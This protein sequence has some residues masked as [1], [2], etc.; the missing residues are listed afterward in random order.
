MNT[1]LKF[2]PEIDK[3]QQKN[4]NGTIYHLDITS[5]HLVE[6]FFFNVFETLDPKTISEK[7]EWLSKS[8]E[9]RIA[10]SAF[11]YG[12][13]YIVKQFKTTEW[14]LLID[15]DSYFA[16]NCLEQFMDLGARW[17]NHIPI[18]MGDAIP[19]YMGGAGLLFNNHVKKVLV[20]NI[21]TCIK[22]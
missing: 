9:W 15:T 14:S 18:A 7:A 1:R 6:E 5:I 3:L 21:D 8:L 2:V 16:A 19:I 20:E 17:L 22:N 12:L 10:Q 4:Q 11:I 13:E